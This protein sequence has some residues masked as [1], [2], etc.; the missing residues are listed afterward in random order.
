M[1]QTTKAPQ[2]VARSQLGAR[3][4]EL[5]EQAE[6]TLVEAA[7]RAG[8]DAGTLSRVENGLRGLKAK[9]AERLLDGYGVSDAAVRNE[10][11]ELIRVDE[12]RRRR[13]AWWRRH[14]EVVSPTQF[15]GYLALESNT[16]A[17]RNYE[18][19][20]IPGLLQTPEYAHQVIACM[21]P[22][23]GTAQIKQLVEIR[24]ARQRRIVDGEA[25]ELFALIDEAAL[26]RP[27][28][29]AQIMRSQLERLVETSQADKTA[30]RLSPFS[31]GPHPGMAGGFVIMSFP[32]VAR[33]IVW[34]ETMRRSAY[35][36]EEADVERYTSVFADLWDRAL[37]PDDTRSRLKK[38]IK[39]LPQ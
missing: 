28:G 11:L 12:G 29:D 38:M 36:D 39:E 23:L 37:G 20:L 35:F 30:I 32:T 33:D 16:C 19:L 22:E 24:M 2:S 15:D 18:P 5:R 13:P 1:P 17:L 9:T 26:L 25:T 14:H 10:V 8:T 4:C 21:R 3:L 31:L 27:V 7:Q 6:L 34:V